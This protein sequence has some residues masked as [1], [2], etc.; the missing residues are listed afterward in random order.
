VPNLIEGSGDVRQLGT[1]ALTFTN[2][3]TYTGATQI[4]GGTLAL[5]GLGS[6]QASSG[7]TSSAAFDISGVTS[8][9][10]VKT[11]TAVADST[12]VLGAKVL[13]ISNSTGTIEGV[14]SGVDGSLILSAGTLT[15]SGANTFTGSTTINGGVLNITADANLG[16][17]P[18]LASSSHLVLN[19]GVLS[20]G[21]SFSLSSNRELSLGASGGT[22]SV[23]TGAAVVVSSIV[24]GTTLTKTGAGQLTLSGENTFSDGLTLSAG[25]LSVS[26]PANLGSG[27]I[28]LNSGTLSIL[29]GSIFA[30]AQNISLSASSTLTNANTAGTTFSGNISASTLGRKS[31]TVTGIGNTNFATGTISNGVGT[32]ALVKAGN[33]T[34]T[35]SGT[36]SYLGG[37]TISAGRLVLDGMATLPTGGDVSVS[38]GILDLGTS[39]ATVGYFSVSNG[40][41]VGSGTIAGDAFADTSATAGSISANLG[42]FNRFSKLG[43]GILTL[44]GNNSYANYYYIGNGTLALGSTNA[45]GKQWQA[46]VTYTT[47]DTQVFFGGKIYAVSADG[48]STSAPTNTSGASLAADTGAVFTWLS[49]GATIHLSGSTLRAFDS[50]DY[51]NRFNSNTCTCTIDTNGQNITWASSFT[52][53]G[54]V[55]TG[56]GTLTLTGSNNLTS[57]GSP[58]LQ[59]NGGVVA[60][61]SVGALG[62]SPLI[63]FGGGS[64]QYS[65]ANTTDYSAFFSQAANQLFKIDTNGQN[66]SFATGLV[67]DSGSL[68]KLGLGRLTLSGTS[69]Y[70]GATNVI[71]GT[72][73]LDGS[74]SIATSS[75][76][77]AD[78]V[79]DI[80]GTSGASIVSLSSSGSGVGQVN[81]GSQT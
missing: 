21:A 45:L 73:V 23:D 57:F 56:L 76:V 38:E 78:G 69:T 18:A 72:L 62:S 59:I 54:L 16:A 35:L 75:Y 13:T 4:S 36:N 12:I 31:L 9:A 51:S 63:R 1:G 19:G 79:L 7:V 2:I 26:R 41:V 30:S 24:R 14:I 80:S 22:I 71:A 55:K 60:L 10:T 64:L 37:T 53:F 8:S 50:T 34:L 32:L 17:P 33:G 43:N 44:S 11:I 74:G 47:A 52:S 48:V 68:S 3:N 6:I 49:S 40:T 61:G 28:V 39:N 58:S 77:F 25:T 66:V 20:S 29:D 15:L 81:L 5:S 70:T 67:S 42:S 46:G 27:D 65:G